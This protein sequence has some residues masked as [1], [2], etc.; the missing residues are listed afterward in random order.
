M[1]NIIVTE[2]LTVDGVFE[3]PGQWSFAYW[4]EEA[5]RYK[6]DELFSASMCLYQRRRTSVKGARSRTG[7]EMGI[8][9]PAPCLVSKRQGKLIDG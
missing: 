4:S 7:Q 1:R 2:Y 9:K 8:L 3:E 5:M 6:R